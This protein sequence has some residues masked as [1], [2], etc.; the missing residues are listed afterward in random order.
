M[1]VNL[2]HLPTLFTLAIFLSVHL[3]A[4]AS[5]H[6]NAKTLYETTA[7]DTLQDSETTD[8]LFI[9][10]I[11]SLPSERAAKT[12]RIKSLMAKASAN[13]QN[14]ILI[15]DI[16]DRLLADPESELK[17]DETYILFLE[18]VLKSPLLKGAE[19]E[20]AEYR[21][22]MALKNRPGTKAADFN[23]IDKEGS[24]HTLHDGRTDGR[25]LLLFYDPDCDHCIET[26][27]AL[28]TTALPGDITIM[29]IDI[30]GDKE[31]WKRTK[32]SIPA[33]WISGFATDPIEDSETYIFQTMPTLF[34]LD[35]DKTVLQKD[36]SIKKCIIALN[37]FFQ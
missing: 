14:F 6:A 34:L 4:S 31:L 7:A 24:P 26:I 29:A 23:F 18:E 35:K 5:V 9:Q 30:T 27:N 37:E 10:F 8:S 20:R 1:T 25:L 22:E 17:D 3:F 12:D 13:P 16:A 11:A 19:K 15:Y 28:K 2:K 32:H 33:D 21:L 36:T